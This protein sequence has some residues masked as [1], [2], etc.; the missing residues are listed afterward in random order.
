MSMRFSRLLGKTLRHPPS[1]AHLP[2]HQLLVRAGYVRAQDVG[3][4]AYLPLG[5]RT[6]ARVEHVLQTEMAQLGAQ[7]MQL[8]MTD[9]TQVTTEVVRLVGR[10]ID[11]YRQLPILLF[12]ITS[13]AA[14]TAGVRLG[15]FGARERPF[16]HI[17][18]FSKADLSVVPTVESAIENLFSACALET[19]WADAGDEGRR[20]YLLH[21]AGDA[22]LARCP[23]C[24]YTAE[25][26]WAQTRWPEAPAEPELPTEQIA[27]PDCDT[28]ASLAE[29]LNIPASKTLKMVFYSVLGK[30]TCLV[31]RGDRA[32][33][34]GKLARL[35]G[36]RS[37]Y[38]S[39]EDELAAI[40]AVGGYA[41][42]IGLDQSKVRVVADPSARSGKNFVSGANQP[43]YH[44]QNVNIPRDF[45]PRSWVDL[46]L[47]EAGDP[48]PECTV[49]L[50]IEPAFGLVHQTPYAPCQPEAEYQDE[51][52]QDQALWMANW[53]IDLGR[54]MAAI[55]EQHHD[56][57]GPI[58]PSACTPFD[59]HLVALDLRK[60]AVAEHAEAL[61]QQLVEQGFSVLYDDRDGSAGVKFNDADLVGIPLRLTISKR[62]VK[63]GV[64]E[65]K[66]RN[67]RDR[68]KLDDE[69][70]MEL[71]SHTGSAPA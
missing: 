47:I 51:Q 45:A 26:A 60:E 18:G 48:C 52:G 28:I 67:S 70:L 41:S 39:L 57:Y 5:R 8:S 71:L 25:R 65:A 7:E 53:D 12:Q 61:Y 68:I 54:L 27:T 13:Q 30:V 50:D 69:G 2:S 11:S 31:L 4:F 33:D 56:D 9:D 21:S 16:F 19:V 58:W 14:P 36:T 42:P 1:D 32:V 20:A 63:E 55:V 35:L 17:H 62:S 40:G 44:I 49:G 64:V 22:E 23:A 24:G 59:I 6:L 43:D 38:A 34:E 3:R 10:E 66:W 37:Y 46:A 29:F 15:L